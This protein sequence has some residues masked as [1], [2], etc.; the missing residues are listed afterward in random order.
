M[1]R[2]LAAALFACWAFSAHGV[3]SRSKCRAMR[4]KAGSML[5]PEQ[6]K[7]LAP[8][9]NPELVAHLVWAR[10]KLEAAGMTTQRRLAQFLANVVHET[11][12]LR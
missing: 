2:A 7:R 4:E 3:E 8:N 9:A 11:G 12:G 6:I 5:T 1:R 10:P